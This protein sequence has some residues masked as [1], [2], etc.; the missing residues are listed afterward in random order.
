MT[1]R[2]SI[3]L[4]A[5]MVTALSMA[6]VGFSADRTASR[7]LREGTVLAGVDGKVVA[8]DA[9]DVWLFELAAD[10][11]NVSGRISAGTRFTLLPSTVLEDLIADA[12]DRQAPRYRLSATVTRY[13]GRNF[14]FPTYFLPL[15]K[16]KDA[17]R[18]ARDPNAPGRLDVRPD[19]TIPPEVLEK[20][21][22]QPGRA[23]RD[24]QRGTPSLRKLFGRI[25]LD[26][27]GRVVVPGDDRASSG[28]RAV[29]VPY[30]LG[31]NLA[32]THYELLPCTTLESV[33]KRQAAAPE[34]IR[35]Q[36]A[37]MVTQF[38]GKEYLLLQRAIRA[39]S[40]GNFAP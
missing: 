20:L 32:E 34:P 14:L 18:A 36:V 19:L 38:Q 35:F 15:S 25:L 31:W 28:Q 9:N 13:E 16:L 24:E 23:R 22:S 2:S 5:A 6:D 4:T 1:S 7:L 39:Y 8:T 10:V 27:V 29:F 21:Q 17:E 12:N 11:N 40:Y 26:R 30:A 33:L 37:G 3:V